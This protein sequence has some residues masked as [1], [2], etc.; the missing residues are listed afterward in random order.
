MR[1]VILANTV[2]GPI[3]QN[4]TISRDP[5]DNAMSTVEGIETSTMR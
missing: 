3:A 2:R 4:S 5:I 1:P